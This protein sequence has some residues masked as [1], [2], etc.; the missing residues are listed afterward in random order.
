MAAE[1]YSEDV[2]RIV[3]EIIDIA[4]VRGLVFHAINYISAYE[5]QII[6]FVFENIEDSE[7]LHEGERKYLIQ[8]IKGMIKEEI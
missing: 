4:D 3:D 6:D 1:K 5:D 8:R 2:T 7:E